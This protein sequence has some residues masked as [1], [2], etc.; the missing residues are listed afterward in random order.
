MLLPHVL[1]ICK[2]LEAKRDSPYA[3]IFIDRQIASLKQ[4]GV[5]VSTFDMGM[6]RSW[7]LVSHSREGEAL[8]KKLATARPRAIGW[9]S[10]AG[11]R[12]RIWI[13][14]KGIH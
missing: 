2:H 8:A 5:R 13:L 6:V 12:L 10:S 9:K 11:G 1:M 14:V 3:G 7:E 4:V